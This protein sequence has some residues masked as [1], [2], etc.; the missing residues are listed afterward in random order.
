MIKPSITRHRF[1]AMMLK[2]NDHSFCLQN[3]QDAYGFVRAV[4]ERLRG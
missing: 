4:T 1:G 2:T 3:G